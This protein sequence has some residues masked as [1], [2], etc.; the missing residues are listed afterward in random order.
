VRHLDLR[1]AEADRRRA[2]VDGR[3]F[4]QATEPI[5][6]TSEAVLRYS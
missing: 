3:A 1:I 6:V 4:A 2:T 5:S